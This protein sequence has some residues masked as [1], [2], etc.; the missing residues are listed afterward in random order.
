[1]YK[2]IEHQ[3]KGSSVVYW[4]HTARHKD[5]FTEG[6]IGI[7]NQKAVQ[8]W[9]QHLDNK[10]SMVNFINNN[11]TLLIYE[12]ILVADNREYCE[13]IE[14]KLRPLLNIGWNVAMGGK[15]GYVFAGAAWMKNK[16]VQ[17][18]ID[19]PIEASNRWWKNECNLLKKQTTAQRIAQ[20]QASKHVP[21]TLDRKH[22]PRNKS[23]FA[24][25]SWFPKYGKWRAQ[26]GMIPI[27]ISLG[28]FELQEQAHQTFLKA[29]A[30]RLM[31]RQGRI[32]REGAITQIKILQMGK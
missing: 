16:W 17:H 12:I 11:G 4:I 25:V 1:M 24:G 21:Y 8:R 18:W 30:I 27:T 5:M 7:T 13:H 23:G 32:D 26:I 2:G 9:K 31:W 20:R 22:D 28:Y 10:K 29:D 15:D 6:Y 3:P 19:N 14:K